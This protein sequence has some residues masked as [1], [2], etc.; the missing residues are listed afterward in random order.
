[1]AA[2]LGT[3][4]QILRLR[5]GAPATMTGVIAAALAI[6]TFAVFAA[7]IWAGNHQH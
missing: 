7:L 2:A 3:V 1:V 6:L 4:S 5:I